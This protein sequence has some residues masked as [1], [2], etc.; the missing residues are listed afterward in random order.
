MVKWC[1]FW[2][3]GKQGYGNRGIQDVFYSLETQDRSLI[4]QVQDIFKKEVELAAMS[5]DVAKWLARSCT[6]SWQC[7]TTCHMLRQG[8]SISS[9]VEEARPLFQAH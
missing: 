3:K 6:Q 4:L 1:G 8:F 5:E 9:W 2:S 7:C